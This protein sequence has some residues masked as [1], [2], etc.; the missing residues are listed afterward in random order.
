MVANAAPLKT[1]ALFVFTMITAEAPPFQAETVPSSVT[2][3]K[4]AGLPFA[5]WKSCVPLKTW[6]VGVPVGLTLGSP[7]GIVT[8][9]GTMLPVPEYSVAS[10]VPLSDTHIGEVELRDM[11]HGFT[12]FGSVVLATPDVSATRFVCL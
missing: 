2:K 12:R 1:D 5:S 6:P 7:V 3:M 4:A 9:R 10:P 8:T 11:P